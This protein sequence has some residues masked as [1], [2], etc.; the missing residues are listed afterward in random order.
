[1]QD[2][3]I[4]IPEPEALQAGLGAQLEGFAQVR[5]VEAT[6]STNA[7][8]YEQA[9]SAAPAALR[10]WLLGAHLQSHGRGRA[11]RGWQNR[12][13]ANLMFSC[14]FDVFL[15]AAR[16]PVL[17]PLAGVAAAESLR[18]LIDPAHAPRLGMKWP[19]DIQ[20]D[21]AKLAGI[22]V[23]AT[24]AGTARQ[25]RDHH[26]AIIGLGLN[27]QDARSLSQSMNRRIADWQEVC[28]C[29]AQ[30]AR[31]DAVTL[32]AAIARAWQDGLHRALRHG[33]DELPER[34]RRVDVLAGQAVDVHDQGRLLHHG[35]A[36]GINPHGQLLLR[37]PEGERAITVGDVSVRLRT[38]PPQPREAVRP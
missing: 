26:V 32:V 23:E 25:A 14:A 4:F 15:P 7:D 21:G 10:P 36:C 20:W 24:R 34:Y 3:S 19:N 31:V 28:A 22:L 12:R 38:A 17:A 27:L 35:H 2:S 8:L 1:M 30:A 33:L 13:G 18:R 5:W 29:D 16:L 9:R 37:T 11:G 6:G